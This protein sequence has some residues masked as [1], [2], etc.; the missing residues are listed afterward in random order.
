MAYTFLQN[1]L[2]EL[3][4]PLNEYLTHTGCNFFIMIQKNKHC[5]V[6]KLIILYFELVLICDDPITQQL[7]PTLS[8]CAW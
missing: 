5:K 1:L 7:R 4:V 6:L 3:T 8:V 2:R